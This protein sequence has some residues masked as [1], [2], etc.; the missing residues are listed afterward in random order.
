MTVDCLQLCAHSRAGCFSWKARKCLDFKKNTWRIVKLKSIILIIS[1]LFLSYVF[2]RVTC[3]LIYLIGIIYH[4]EPCSLTSFWLFDWQELILLF[5]QS[6]LQLSMC[7]IVILF[8]LFPHIVTEEAKPSS[9]S[10]PGSQWIW[11]ESDDV[12]SWL[13]Q[14][15]HQQGHCF[16]SNCKGNHHAELLWHLQI[17]NKILLLKTPHI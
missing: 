13:Q 11:E 10:K 2:L 4:L 8:F 17:T 1:V 15:S 12:C 3:R 6:A 14:C 16:Q 9:A 5:L 7:V